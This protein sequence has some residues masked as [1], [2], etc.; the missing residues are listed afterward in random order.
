MKI[1]SD[2]WTGVKR[3]K[4]KETI[5]VMQQL[6]EKQFKAKKQFQASRGFKSMT[7]AISNYAAINHKNFNV[8]FK[9][10]CNTLGNDWSFGSPAF[11]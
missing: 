5:T 8:F 6:K 11:L 1:N 3:I 2:I 10:Q 4:E 9:K 7:F